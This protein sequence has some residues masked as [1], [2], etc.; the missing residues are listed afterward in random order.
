MLLK[1]ILHLIPGIAEVLQDVAA[2]KANCDALAAASAAARNAPDGEV[3]SVE[4]A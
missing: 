3:I 2:L 1:L 4:E